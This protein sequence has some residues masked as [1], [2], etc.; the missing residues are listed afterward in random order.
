MVFL[1]LYF[2][3][4]R[5]LALLFKSAIVISSY[6][7]IAVHTTTPYVSRMFPCMKMQYFIIIKKRR[8]NVADAFGW[9]CKGRRGNITLRV[10]WIKLWRHDEKGCK[11]N[12]R[13]QTFLLFDMAIQY[14]QARLEWVSI[15]Y[16]KK[17]Y[18]KRSNNI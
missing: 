16:Y 15:K 17:K 13:Q 3:L 7:I 4:L 2:S 18:F 6:L 14:K 10:V 5:P 12:F 9:K 11:Y 8:F 1:L